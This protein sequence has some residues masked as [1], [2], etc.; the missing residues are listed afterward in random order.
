MKSNLTVGNKKL[1]DST[2]N[3]TYYGEGSEDKNSRGKSVAKETEN[4]KPWRRRSDEDRGKRSFQ[5]NRS[6]SNN[7]RNRSRDT[8]RYRSNGTRDTSRGERDSYRRSDRNDS[9]RNRRFSRT[10]EGD[11]YRKPERYYDNRKSGGS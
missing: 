2:E 10:R 4:S 11:S 6:N 1:E 7:G 9:S 3:K 5:N 8:N